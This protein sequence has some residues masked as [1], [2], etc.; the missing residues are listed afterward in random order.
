M[1]KILIAAAQMWVYST[2]G[3]GLNATKSG[4]QRYTLW[5]H[6]VTWDVANLD[7]TG[8]QMYTNICI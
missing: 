4:M 6:Y 3:N 1:Y 5:L 2:Q 8:I 7:H